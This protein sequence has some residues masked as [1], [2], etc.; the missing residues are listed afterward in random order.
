METKSGIVVNIRGMRESDL[1]R[2]IE[3]QAASYTE[4]APES[5]ESLLAKLR[6]SPTTCFV[7]ESEGSVGGYLFSL[8]WEFLN[9]PRLNSHECRLPLNPD[10]LYLHDLAIAP[11]WRKV[12]AGRALVDAFVARLEPLGLGRASLIAV[13]GSSSYWRRYGFQ[14]VPLTEE[15]REKLSS[16]GDG[17]VYMEKLV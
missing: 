8:P 9:P 5:G 15:L 4:V 13:Q 12:G 7:A 10:C 11:E 3:I 16:Y 1:P 14:P 17:V 2:I 6:A